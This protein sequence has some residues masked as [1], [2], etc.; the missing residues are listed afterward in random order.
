MGTFP[1][2]PFI[3]ALGVL[4]LVGCAQPEA[5]PTSPAL[6]V[7]T[8]TPATRGSTPEGASGQAEDIRFLALG[9]S[10]TIGHGVDVGER[11]PVQLVQRLREDDINMAEPE[12][13][14][15]T[16]WTAKELSLAIDDANPHGPYDLVTVMIGVNDQVRGRDVEE[17]R[18][19]FEV[20]LQRAVVFAGGDPSR[21]I[22]LSIPDWSVTPFAEGRDRLQ[23]SAEIELFNA[24]NR[25]ESRRVGVRYVD[26]TP[27][28]RE[29]ETNP[30]FLADDQLHPSGGMYAAWTDLILPEARAILKKP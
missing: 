1:H 15:R 27:I 2:W 5:T 8:P 17:Y 7:R 4:V 9:D 12:I 28:S 16:G 13:I 24:V 22:I 20:L 21:V 3:F 30:K 11:W 26:I 19:E 14:A 10:Y 29:A 25:N 18:A 6:L 23:I